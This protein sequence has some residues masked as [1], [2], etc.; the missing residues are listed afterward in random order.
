M[1]LMPAICLKLDECNSYRQH[2]NDQGD[3]SWEV[4]PWLRMMQEIRCDLGSI[5]KLRGSPIADWLAS[6]RE[7]RNR[8]AD[9]NDDI[10]K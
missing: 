9:N 6:V 7:H 2:E 4:V 1:W 10:F 8:K 3:R 5:R